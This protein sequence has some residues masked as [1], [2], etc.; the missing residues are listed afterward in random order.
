[1]LSD[2]YDSLL[3]NSAKRLKT[4]L[5]SVNSTCTHG[6]FLSFR[7]TPLFNYSSVSLIYVAIFFIWRSLFLFLVSSPVFIHFERMVAV[8]MPA[9]TT[10]ECFLHHFGALLAFS[11]RTDMYTNVNT[12]AASVKKKSNLLIHNLKIENYFFHA[13]TS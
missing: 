7:G 2:E 3:I 10:V 6:P 1:M 9:I 12:T 4:E 11:F 8:P 13:N 5:I